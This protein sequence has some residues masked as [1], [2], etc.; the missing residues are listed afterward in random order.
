M[1]KENHELRVARDCSAEIIYA[2]R[3]A[4]TDNNTNAFDC[5]ESRMRHDPD[6]KSDPFMAGVRENILDICNACE[7]NIAN[8]DL[9]NSEIAR[10]TEEIDKALDRAE[11]FKGVA[12]SVYGITIPSRCNGKQAFCDIATG[13]KI[14]IDKK[15]YDELV[16]WI[17]AINTTYDT[18]F[19]MNKPAYLPI[20]IEHLN[21]LTK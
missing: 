4:I 21:D 7:K 16:E 17:D 15:K 3:C 14:L 11:K 19:F 2:I 8:N 1:D 18:M 9:K 10:L 13:K 6:F 5:I 20:M 12:N